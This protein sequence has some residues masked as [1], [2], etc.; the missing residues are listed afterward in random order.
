MAHP[1][2][3]PPGLPRTLLHLQTGASAYLVVDEQTGPLERTGKRV[4]SGEDALRQALE[5]PVHPVGSR[6]SSSSSVRTG[7]AR[8]P[9]RWSG[10]MLFLTPCAQSG[11]QPTGCSSRGTEGYQRRDSSC[12]P[13]INQASA[14]PRERTSSICCSSPNAC[15][16]S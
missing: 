16:S 8:I 4:E 13:S 6:T 10:A 7:S 9:R 14:S 3:L 11:C 1:R 15:S 5:L 2:D 12:E